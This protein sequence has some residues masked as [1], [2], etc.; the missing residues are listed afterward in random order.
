MKADFQ[1]DLSK[2]SHLENIRDKLWLENGNSRVS[3]MVGAGFSLNGNKLDESLES[4]S[5]WMD[6]KEKIEK[7][8]ELTEPTESSSVLEL[9]Q[10]YVDEYGRE[11]LED[12]LKQ[13]I[14]DENYEPGELHKE[15]LRLPWSDVYTTNYDTLLERTL[16]FIYERAY[17]VIYE[18]RDIPN[19]V[20]PRIVK[21]HG[22]FPS[23]RPFVFTEK[24]YDNYSKNSAP[25]VNMV[26]QSIMETTLV[27]IGFS[28][29]DPNFENWTQ[30]VDDNL[31]EHKPK[32][33][34]LG[35]GEANNEEKLNKRGITLIDFKEIYEDIQE[36][37][38]PY[39]LMFSDIFEFLSNKDKKD[40]K[41]WPY[42]SYMISYNSRN[43]N[44]KVDDEIDKI[45]ELFQENRKN[46]PGWLILPDVI[47]KR[48]IKTVQLSCNNLMNLIFTKDVNLN[49]KV[50]ALNEITWVY[51]T[52]H[53]P[54]SVR[55]QKI[56][57]R[58]VEELVRNNEENNITT[59]E[60]IILR[61]LK[62][63]RLDFNIENFEKY[64]NLLNTFELSESSTNHFIYEKVLMKITKYEYSEAKD[65]INNWLFTTNDLDT[66]NLE[67]KVKK[68]I[69]LLLLGFKKDSIELLEHCLNTVRRI[70][71]LKK[72]N[73]K[74]Y[75]L[76]G[77]ILTNL[78]DLKESEQDTAQ[79]LSFLES[80]LAD[81]RKELDFV[82][83]RIKPYENKVGVFERKSFDPHRKIQ[84]SHF[85]NDM[86]PALIDSY[87][88]LVL[89][90]EYN[91][92]FLKKAGKGNIDSREV[93]NTAIEN[94]VVLYPIYSWL[95]FLRVS[96]AKDSDKLFN[97]EVVYKIEPDILSTFFRI[98]VNGIENRDNII[99]L[100]EILSRVYFSL[101]E[102][103]KIRADNLVFDIYKDK[104]V[105]EP[106]STYQLISTFKNLF[107][108]ILI[109]KNRDE[110]EKFIEQIYNLPIIGDPKG[111]LS[112]IKNN[113]LNFYDP[114]FSFNWKDDIKLDIEKVE[115]DKLTEIIKGPQRVIRDAA[116]A[117]LIY[118][119]ETNNLPITTSKELKNGITNILKN[120][121]EYLSDYFLKS[122]LILISEDKELQKEYSKDITRKS[123]PE[124]Y[125]NDNDMISDEGLGTY[126]S[127]LR[128]VFSNLNN[129]QSNLSV[130]L[131][132]EDYSSWLGNFYKWWISQKEWL[133]KK[134]SDSFGIFNDR[135]REELKQIIYFL[136]DVF[137]STI[138]KEYF[139][140]EDREKLNNI[141]CEIKSHKKDHSIL[142]V[143]VLFR[144]NILKE[145][146]INQVY[147]GLVE[148][149]EQLANSSIKALSDLTSLK[150]RN[151]IDI[152]WAKLKSYLLN[153]YSV[154]K[155][156][157]M[158][159]LTGAL[160][161]II[162]QAPDFF[163]NEEY[164]II[165]DTLSLTY[166]DFKEKTDGNYLVS[167]EELS[168]LAISTRLAGEIYM[169]SENFDCQLA[170]W[171][172]LSEKS[173]LPE[174]R[175]YGYFFK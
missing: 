142:L 88:L 157:T 96:K 27:L 60:K 152:E 58:V 115:I 98:I 51:E 172:M 129:K 85:R 24:D 170:N 14:P 95:M 120:K 166:K 97:R 11:S 53:I 112:K 4:I 125:N 79:R 46:Y 86:D 107:H 154:R 158:L 148:N 111:S 80:K 73:Y 39:E 100:L 54:M 103:E 140:D 38:N 20:A 72:D 12:I 62:E 19:S 5:N 143:P 150:E 146:E 36:D 171:K 161:N 175:E 89:S 61:L 92:R 34:M 93:V 116:L 151:E 164:S 156:L 68:G 75:S 2:Y 3:V 15:F 7:S 136:K 28:G 159:E 155:E 124:S 22:S 133:L 149:D 70:L 31:G 47:K 78:I 45:I 128:N 74:F 30:W 104:G 41:D 144:N 145:N 118:L 42:N 90:E 29:E 174:V 37:A 65:E 141:Y 138:P 130:F 162:H 56:M 160:S 119:K 8:L 137:L 84:T 40:T 168:L 82:Y 64:V 114:S 127:N 69:L 94:M 52:F 1:K 16:P 33:Y 91:L 66:N 55:L 59:I 6:I 122:Y 139:E 101:K 105:Y 13:T 132:K 35:Y 77:I 18:S 57:E 123:L 99:I 67:W 169:L 10:R 106:N 21:L 147:E 76:E 48:R 113:P 26:Q 63:A 83:S 23:N 32:I 126:L 121:N 153:F 49:K 43:L 117:R 17:Q 81:P 134:D 102:N 131:D 173:R 50:E 163:T 108:R 109:D 135:N 44:D 167:N 110:K 165:V 9:S 87:A 25:M 71:S